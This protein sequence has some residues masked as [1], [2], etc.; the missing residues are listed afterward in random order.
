MKKVFTFRTILSGDKDVYLDQIYYPLNVSSYKRKNIIIDDYESLEQ[1]QRVCLVGVAGQGKTMT[2]KKMFL[3]DL[4]KSLFFPIFLSFR[5]LDFS[6]ELSLV[7]ALET[8]FITNGVD[9]SKTDV[10]ALLKNNPVRLY[11]DGF[12]E[13]P[14]SHRKRA[15]KI[16]R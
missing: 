6:K 14:V 5:N 12:D 7:E 10:S 4:N 8:H 3:E 9:C 1:E 2:M 15:N 16:L 13:I 11:L